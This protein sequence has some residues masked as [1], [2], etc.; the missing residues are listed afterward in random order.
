MKQRKQRFVANNVHTKY[1]N[2]L[3]L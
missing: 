1:W 3:N 2:I